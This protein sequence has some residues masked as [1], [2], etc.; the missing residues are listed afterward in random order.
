MNRRLLNFTL[1]IFLLCLSIPAYSQDEDL[2]KHPRVMSFPPFHM[3]RPKP[4]AQ[5]SPT[6]WSFTFW[7]TRSCPWCMFP[8]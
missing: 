5:S 2:L 4:P 1:L 7:K 6:G 8:P 3:F